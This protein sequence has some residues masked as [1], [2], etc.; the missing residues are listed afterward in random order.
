MEIRELTGEQIGRIYTERM[1]GDFSPDEIK[2]LSRIEE[3]LSAGK[4]ACYG[5]FEKDQILAYAFFV[6]NDRSALLDYLAVRE[7]L[8]GKG[9]GSEFIRK[10]ADG[11]TRR[12]ETVLL[13]SEDP[14][15]ADS[16]DERSVMERRLRF[17]RGNGLTDTGVISTVWH[18]PYKILAFPSEK[19]LSADEAGAVYREI[20]RVIFPEALYKRMV[21]VSA[22]VCRDSGHRP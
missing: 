3:A 12:F 15:R 2:P 13:E 22:A 1:P 17:Y 21:W 10:M 6:I 7:D 8:R 5:A 19:T 11:L 20:Y 16:E 4:Y 9:I 18:V 14:D